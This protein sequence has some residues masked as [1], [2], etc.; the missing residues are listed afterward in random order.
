MHLD[1]TVLLV[2]MVVAMG[3][4]DEQITV[5]VP[6]Q[7]ELVLNGSRFKRLEPFIACNVRTLCY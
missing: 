2:A 1:E 4:H 7:T 6:V 3:T 5:S